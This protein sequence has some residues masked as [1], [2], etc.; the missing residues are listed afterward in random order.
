MSTPSTPVRRRGPGSRADASHPTRRELLDAAITIADRGG[1]EQLSVNEVTRQAGLAK[2]TF[3]V[4]FPD[5]AALLLE[6]H[7]HF[8]DELFAAIAAATAA[9][10]PGPSRVQ[11]RISAFLDGCRQQPGVRAMLLQ[12]RSE[13]AIFSE[14]TRRNDQA[15]RLLAG[16]LRGVAAYPLGRA[17]LLVSATAEVALEELTAGRSLP[18]LRG[19]LAALIPG[20]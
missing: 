2:G 14:V 12:A 18:R 13:P 10:N 6:L 8:H 3:Y 20:H 16:D 1:L 17:R 4:H 11:R 15:A 19:E 7:R 5:R 9:D